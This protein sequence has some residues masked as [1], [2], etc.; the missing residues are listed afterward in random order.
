GSRLTVANELSLKALGSSW[1]FYK[2]TVSFQQWV[3]LRWGHVLSV[4]AL[5]GVIVGEAPIFERYYLGDVDPLVPSRALGLVLSTLPAR[6]LLH[7]GI[8]RKRYAPL[9]GRVML[10][11]AV[12]LFRG[13]RQVYGGDVF[14][15]VGL[16]GLADYDDLRFADRRGWSAAP[17]D[18]LL[19]VG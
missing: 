4:G 6:D 17:V 3:R 15:D 10:E 9:V 2:L 12:P 16:L 1:S 13:G 7:S 18:L 19:D 8:E 5:A 11:Y 14:F